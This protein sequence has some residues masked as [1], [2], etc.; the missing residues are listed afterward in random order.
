MAVEFRKVVIRLQERLSGLGGRWQQWEEREVDL[1][2][3]V[4]LLSLAL[5]FLV[6]LGSWVGYRFFW[7]RFDRTPRLE[8]ELARWTQAVEADEGNAEAHYQLGWVLFQKGALDEAAKHYGRTLE[9]QPEH[10]GARYNLGMV[11][12]EKKMYGEAAAEF[13]AVADKYPRHEQAYQGLGLAYL[14]GGAVG[15]GPGQPA[16]PGMDKPDFGGRPL[17]PWIGLRTEGEPAGGHPGDAG[18]P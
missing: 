14:E 18:G 5:V 3:A 8:R 11:Y 7:N 17:L 15:T 16:T 9:L 13:K 10:V 12:L 1:T 4:G 2:K 6:L